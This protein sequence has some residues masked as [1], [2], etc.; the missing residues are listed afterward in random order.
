MCTVDQYT[1]VKFG[2]MFKKKSGIF[3]TASHYCLFLL[4]PINYSP[5]PRPVVTA[6]TWYYIQGTMLYYCR[7]RVS[8]QF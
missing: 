7:L 4:A 2:L 3:M 8:V 6:T 5:D 1:F